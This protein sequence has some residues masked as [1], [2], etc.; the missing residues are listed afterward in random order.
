MSGRVPVA[1]EHDFLP[2]SDSHF[3]K[4]INAQTQAVGAGQLGLL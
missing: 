1:A 2:Q 3:I 4:A